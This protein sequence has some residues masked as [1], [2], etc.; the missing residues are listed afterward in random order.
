MASTKVLC[1]C[2]N[3]I[4]IIGIEPRIGG[5]DVYCVVCGTVTN[6]STN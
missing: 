3:K 1:S 2:G 4:D 5:I 6:H